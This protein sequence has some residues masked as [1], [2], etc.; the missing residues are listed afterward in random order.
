MSTFI[1]TV[2][3]GTMHLSES[4]AGLILELCYGI[5]EQPTK[6]FQ[7]KTL[8]T[9][10]TEIEAAVL[11]GYPFD[12]S[13]KKLETA[14]N[15]DLRCQKLESETQISHLKGIV[16]EAEKLL[17]EAEKSEEADAWTKETEYRNVLNEAIKEL[18]KIAERKRKADEISEVVK[19]ED[20]EG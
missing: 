20:E 1:V 12:V 14:N 2:H 9:L 6:P 11:K 8:T 3:V 10:A 4:D 5:Q 13:R 16:L 15:F 17:Q 18:E 7:E 19:V